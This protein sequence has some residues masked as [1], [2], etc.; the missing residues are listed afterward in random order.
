MNFVFKYTFSSQFAKNII[1]TCS[2]DRRVQFLEK[3]LELTTTEV[4]SDLFQFALR[5]STDTVGGKV[6]V[7]CLYTAKT[8]QVLVALFLPF[9]DQVLVCYVLLQA[10]LVKF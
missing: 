4:V 3:F 8:T 2:L 5:Y 10:V 1:K 9:C 6:S 7:S